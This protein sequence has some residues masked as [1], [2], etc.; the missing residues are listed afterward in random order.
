M[1]VAGTERTLRRALLLERHGLIDTALDEL[2]RMGL[3]ITLAR[4]IFNVRA[5]WTLDRFT[6]P[7]RALG[8]PPLK[9]G[10]LKG[11]SIDLNALVREYLE[12]MGWDVK[13]G[14]PSREVLRELNL[15]RFLTGV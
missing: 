2:E 9:T 4:H 3:R 5:G 12:E 13:T 15:A 14:L 7:D 6:F 10:E 11:V 1:L 8:K